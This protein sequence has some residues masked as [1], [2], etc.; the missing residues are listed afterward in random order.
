V[1][2]RAQLG[3][4]L[5]AKP[6]VLAN[7]RPVVIGADDH[8]PL[9][10]PLRATA[11]GILRGRVKLVLQAA[12]QP[13]CCGGPDRRRGFRVLGAGLGL[14]DFAAGSRPGH[15]PEPAGSRHRPGGRWHRC[16]CRLRSEAVSFAGRERRFAVA[17]VAACLRP[18]LLLSASMVGA[19]SAPGA[20][21]HQLD[22]ISSAVACWC[23]QIQGLA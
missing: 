1:F 6:G 11:F 14:G 2:I 19:R 21:S 16:L 12:V 20:V 22:G 8:R 15:G 13:C 18:G 9:D 3:S 5:I 4:S 23:W 7:Q 10:H 17:L